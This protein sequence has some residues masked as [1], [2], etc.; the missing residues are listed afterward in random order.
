MWG[1]VWGWLKIR[2][3]IKRKLLEI[4]LTEDSKALVPS[5]PSRHFGKMSDFDRVSKELLLSELENKKLRSLLSRICN[6]RVADGAQQSGFLKEA[7]EL[8]QIPLSSEPP[9]VELLDP[10]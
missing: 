4:L 3:W 7:A 1:R 8:L 6:W 2:L 10:E 5:D 9:E